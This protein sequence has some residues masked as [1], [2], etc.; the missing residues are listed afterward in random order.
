MSEGKLN[1]DVGPLQKEEPPGFKIE[2]LATNI[3]KPSFT[4]LVR[5]MDWNNVTLPFRINYPSSEV[6]GVVKYS[7]KMHSPV[8]ATPSDCIQLGTPT[9]FRSSNS[10]GNSELMGDD[11]ESAYTEKLDWGRVGSPIMESMKKHLNSSLRSVADNIQLEIGWASDNVF[12][13]CTSITP[14][15]SYDRK[16]QKEYISPDYEFATHIVRPSCFATEL[17]YQF[18]KQIDWKMD[19]KAGPPGMH[20]LAARARTRTNFL[21]E[22]LI[23]VDHGSVLYLTEE[24][25]E[26]VMNPQ[27]NSG[28]D[29]ILPF[30]KRKKYEGQQEYRFVIDV[31]FHRIGNHADDEDGTFLVKISEK[32]R[33]LMS[34]IGRF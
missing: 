30:L 12:I 28:Y 23:F 24:E 32:L 8:S 18:G 7:R 15:T 19:L 4:V 11:R 27:H 13:Y 21:G 20:V 33:N 3:E 25:I 31:H 16:L 17:G 10:K 9:Y 22:Y 26:T 29:R 6:K 5:R 14:E 34:P 2:S 1:L